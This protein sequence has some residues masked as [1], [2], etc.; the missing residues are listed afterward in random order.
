MWPSLPFSSRT[1]FSR[2]VLEHKVRPNRRL[3]ATFATRIEPATLGGLAGLVLRL[4]QDGHGE[5][6][7]VGP[8][9]TARH[10]Q[11]LQHVIRW[12]HPTVR[13]YPPPYSAAASA[14]DSC[15]GMEPERLISA[16]GEPPPTNSTTMK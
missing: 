15:S 9:G 6:A 11:G 3:A 7:V 13:P 5:L 12:R 8:P 10:L 2:L 1:G 14:M 4:S 16:D